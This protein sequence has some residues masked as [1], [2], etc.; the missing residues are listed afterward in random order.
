M[1]YKH[2]ALITTGLLIIFGALFYGV[3][4][5]NTDPENKEPEQIKVYSDIERQ[6]IVD[7]LETNNAKSSDERKNILK[8][9]DSVNNSYSH[10]ER[11]NILERL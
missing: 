11:V 7:S 8:S 4:Y 1:T 3:R 10:S 6:N 2:I 5:V 9:L